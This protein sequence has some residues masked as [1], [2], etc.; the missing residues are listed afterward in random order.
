M[1]N[2]FSSVPTRASRDAGVLAPYHTCTRR[3]PL[4]RAQGRIHC[5]RHNT[6]RVLYR[7]RRLRV[8]SRDAS[9]RE[10]SRTRTNQRRGKLSNVNGDDDAN[11]RNE[12]IKHAC[13]VQLQYLH[14]A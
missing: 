10:A 5:H 14:D 2:G 3:R 13:R 9:S 11:E 7:I 4:R 8:V 6:L 1:L 12:T